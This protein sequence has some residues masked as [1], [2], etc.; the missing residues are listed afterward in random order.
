MLEE[1]LAASLEDLCGVMTGE[2][3]DDRDPLVGEAIS[4]S[5]QENALGA[6]RNV[7]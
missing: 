2:K 5:K 7:F 1:H 6:V 4:L 3:V